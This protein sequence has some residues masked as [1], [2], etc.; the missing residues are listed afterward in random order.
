MS[1]KIWV[2]EACTTVTVEI[3]N[4]SL[5]IPITGV[6]I[7]SVSLTYVSGQDFP[8]NDGESGTFTSDQCSG[9]PIDVTYDSHISGQNIT[10]VDCN[11]NS[12]CCDLNGS[13]GTCTFNDPA[14]FCDCTCTIYIIA[15][16]GGCT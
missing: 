11:S 6:S 4:S 3:T 7:N 8:I 9:G 10:I 13:G 16:D 14:V 5:N 15:A 12:N 1:F 2:Q